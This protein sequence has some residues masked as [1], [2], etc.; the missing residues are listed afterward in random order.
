MDAMDVIR[1]AKDLDPFTPEFQPTMGL[2]GK[3]LRI[4]MIF[5]F[6]NLCGGLAMSYKPTKNKLIITSLLL[7]AVAVT[8]AAFVL[9]YLH[10]NP[11]PVE[12]PQ[13][14]DEFQN[15]TLTVNGLVDRTLNLSILD[16]L[17]MPATS[18]DAPL[19]CAGNLVYA[20]ENGTWEGVKLKLVLEEAGIR[21]DAIKVAFYAPDGFSTDLNIQ[22]TQR[23]DVVIAYKKDGEFLTAGDGSPAPRLVV[24]GKWGYKWINAL[25]HAELVDFDFR[26]AYESVGYSDEADIGEER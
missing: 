1:L 18:V 6:E 8:I 15:W 2:L 17:S 3:R 11:T 19:Y 7:V 26:G 20:V 16:L 12:Q 13:L 10:Q 9:L 21:P 4:A 25:N 22:D 23:E 5:R 24:P 14:P